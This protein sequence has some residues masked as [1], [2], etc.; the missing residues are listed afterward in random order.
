MKSAGIR[1]P[2]SAG[3]GEPGTVVT[4]Y[5]FKGGV[6]RTMALVNTA[7]I[8]AGNGLRVLMVD[9]D[10]EAPGLHRYFHPLLTDPELGSTGGVIDLIR[11][12]A[13]RADEPGPGA[14]GSRDRAQ[15]FRDRCDVDRC[16]VGIR[17][18]FPDGGKLDFLPAG[19]Q[20]DGYSAAVSTFDWDHFYTRL[21]GAAFLAALRDELRG[22]YDYVLIDSRTGLSDTAG[23]CTVLLPDVVT[24]CFTLSAQSIQGAA[25]V[26]E[27]VR[28]QVTDRPVRILPAPM[29]VE[30]AE[31]KKLEAGRDLARSRFLSFLE[32]MTREERD[33]YWGDVEIP[34]R[35]F[36]AYEEIPAPVGDRPHQGTSLLAAS[37]RLTGRITGGR[38]TR[39]RP[40]PETRRRALLSRYERTKPPVPSDLFLSYAPADRMWAEWIAARL[41]GLGYEVVL[42]GAAEHAG[43]DAGTEVRRALDGSGRIVVLLSPDYVRLPHA[44][45]V[46]KSVSARDPE[47]SQRMLIPIRIHPAPLAPPFDGLVAV[48]LVERDD[49]VEAEAA[50]LAAVGRPDPPAAETVRTPG[51]ADEDQGPRYPGTPPPVWQMPTRNASFTG[52]GRTLE[53]MRDGFAAGVPLGGPPQAVFGMGGVGKTQV[54]IEYAH[55]FAADYDVVWWVNAGQPSLVR[56][57]LA[58]LA[59]RLGLPSGDDVETTSNAVL[60]ALRQGRP[61]RRWLL[62][63]DNAEHPEELAPL[64]PSGTGHVLVTSRNRAWADRA[65]QVEVDVFTRDESVRLLQRQNP[66]L[67]DADAAQVAEALGDL[68]LAVAQAAAWLEQSAMPVE[69]YLELLSTQLATMLEQEPATTYPRSAAATWLLALG[70]VRESMPAAAQL[71]EICAFFGP[72]PIPMWTLYGQKTAELLARHDRRLVHSV[73]MGALFAEINRYG[74]ART[75]QSDKTIGVHRLVQEVLRAQIPREQWPVMRAHVHAILAEANPRNMEDPASWDRHASLLPH[76]RPSRAF[77]SEDDSVRRWIADSVRYLWRRS[78]HVAAQETAERALAAW[79][80]VFGDDDALVI[81]LRTQYANALRSSGRLEEAYAMDEQALRTAREVL[82]PDDYYT[83][84]AAANL[85]ADLRARGAYRQARDVDNETYAASKRAYEGGDEERLLMAA[86]NLAV[87]KF[88][89]GDRWGARELDR[90]VWEKRKGLLGKHHPYTLTSASNY[91][92]GLRETGSVDEALKLLQETVKAFRDKTGD[93]HPETLQ[94]ARNLSA[95]LRRSGRYEEARALSAENYEISMSVLGPDHPDTLSAAVNL[96]CALVATGDAQGARDLARD[97][98]NRHRTQLGERHPFALAC[99]NN[100]AVYLRLTGERDAALALSRR[101]LHQHREVLGQDNPYTLTSM[102]NHATDLAADG[103]AEGAVRLGRE[104]YDAFVRVL[105]ADHYDAI[106]CA[107]N[108]A[109]DLRDLGEPEEAARLHE[110]ALRRAGAMMG[111]EHPT[112]RAVKEWVRLDS[113]IE[114]PAT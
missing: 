45:E 13:I 113:D 51:D 48:D 78:N 10:L 26:A 72:D 63:F 95:V 2:G 74:L 104:A 42:S 90:E 28:A 64:I 46:W 25:A 98:L 73:R 68:P 53:E 50:L 66:H 19:L 11:D 103:D 65:A 110:D 3:T 5:S 15:W 84:V 92:R 31:Q 77:T 8:L 112:T 67:P 24:V 70:K 102:M 39:Q 94:A 20:D 87:S 41:R 57:E 30:Y 22:R 109:A 52:R 16:I 93:R 43:S 12:Y 83:L 34:Y 106:G 27:S 18:D 61:Y 35:P 99:A 4:F 82:G 101:T 60:E 81:Y 37:E 96:A 76:M 105:T 108:L 55:R 38:V 29:R 17:E 23:I 59:G 49:Q 85:G 40:M 71:L 91:A 9:W 114:P 33:R 111:P 47:A 69:T 89:V 54:A 88:L 56:Q 86:N 32:G 80:P 107:S 14:A 75:N 62:V 21:R 100:L 36:F 79:E 7:W 44:Y 6:G 97:A 1:E 58:T